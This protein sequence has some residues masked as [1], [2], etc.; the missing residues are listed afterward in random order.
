MSLSPFRIDIISIYS[1]IKN[2]AELQ[3]KVVNAGYPLEKTGYAQT[4]IRDEYRK[5]GRRVLPQ[6]GRVP[7]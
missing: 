6:W 5:S 4:G 3:P 7:P 2:A 1:K